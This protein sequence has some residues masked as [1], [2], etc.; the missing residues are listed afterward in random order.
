MR[1]GILAGLF[2]SRTGLVFW[3]LTSSSFLVSYELAGLFTSQQVSLRASRSLYELAGLVFRFIS[4]SFPCGKEDQLITYHPV[5][6]TKR[7]VPG[8]E[9]GSSYTC[10]YHISGTS[11]GCYYHISGTSCSLVVVITTYQPQPRPGSGIRYLIYLSLPHIR[12]L[13]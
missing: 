9:S 11:Y 1:L 4:A 8:Q 10:Y 5:L 6:L 12:Y 3:S 2:A 7:L 13:I